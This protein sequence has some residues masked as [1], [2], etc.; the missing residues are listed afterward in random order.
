MAE[1]GSS[2]PFIAGSVNVGRPTF[3]GNDEILFTSRRGSDKA[4]ALYGI[5]VGGG[6]S[7]RLVEHPNGVGSYLLSPDGSRVAF[8]A[9][10]ETAKE[11][12]NAPREGVQ[13]GNLRGGPASCAALG[14]GRSRAR[15]GPKRRRVEARAGRVGRR[16]RHLRRLEPD[17]RTPRSDHYADR[18]DRRLL[19]E[20]VRRDR[21]RIDGRLPRSLTGRGDRQARPGRV[22]PERRAG[23]RRLGR[24]SARPGG[25]QTDARGQ[26]RRLQRPAAGARGSRRL[27]RLGGRRARPVRGLRRRLEHPGQGVDLGGSGDAGRTGRPDQPRLQPATRWRRGGAGRGQP[28]TIRGRSTATTRRNHERRRCG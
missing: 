7:R 14:R 1:P 12:K 19:H 17:R 5:P 15:C 21:G 28:P 6:E 23:R 20:Q 25:R 24:R 11:L 13:P 8:L 3:R 2:R 4:S 26:R 18:P 27:V 9:R 16:T 10:E 22:Q